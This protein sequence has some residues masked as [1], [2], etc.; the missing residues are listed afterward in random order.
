MTALL[1]VGLVLGQVP[2]SAKTT[3][4]PGLQPPQAMAVQGVTNGVPIPISGTV[5]SAGAADATGSATFNANSVCAFVATAGQFGAGFTLQAGTLAATLTPSVSV[6]STNGT[7]GTW[8][9]T[10]FLDIN[11]NATNSIVAT[12]PNAAIA[13]GL[14]SI[15]GERFARVCT[16]SY[17]SGSAVGNMT[18]STPQPPTPA[19]TSDIT[20]RTARVLGQLTDGSATIVPAKTGQLPA[21]LDASGGVKTHEVGTATVSGTVTTTPPSHAS[22]NVDQVNGTTV[23]TNSGVKSAGTQRVVIATDQPSLTNKLLVTP[24]SVALPAHQSANV[25]QWN[26]NTVD[27][28]SGV[29]SAGTVRVVLATDQP[30][31]TNKLLVTPDSVALPANQSVNVT[32]INSVTPLMGNGVTGTGS[33]R[34]TIAS[35]NTA[36]TVNAAESGTWTVQPGNTANTTPW[37]MKPNDGTNSATI[38]AASTAPA[39]TDTAMVVTQSPNANTL[40]TSTIAVNQTSSTDLKTATNKLHICSIVLVSATAQNISLVEGTNAS[41][42]AGQ[43]AVI[44]GTTASVAL[45]AN[46]GFSAVSDRAWLK[47]SLSAGHLCL[48]Q[49]GAGNVSGVI[50]YAD[51]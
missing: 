51:Q 43:V 3:A 9:N 24:D 13:Y 41:C 11:G 4:P 17:T 27:T 5:N 38:K 44:G 23:D 29:K 45:A 39:T 15:S 48:F 19:A 21:A 18:A 12:N 14:R 47:T 36:F 22:T 28:N 32:Q 40:C 8:T 34:V 35:D 30:S 10:S 49:S 2:Q 37:L 42:A 1:L 16:T 50:T 26:G 46:G 20:D 7:N 6:D 33:Q 25:D 31:L